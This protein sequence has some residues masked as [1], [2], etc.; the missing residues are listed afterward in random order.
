MEKLGMNEVFKHSVKNSA[1]ETISLSV[2]Y[3][4]HEK[5]CSGQKWGKGIRQQ[6][7]LH[8]VVSGKGTYITPEGSF[9]LST[10]DMFLIRPYTEIEYYA[11]END[12]WEYLWVNFTGTDAETL[13]KR[14][15]FTAA[16]PVIH[17]CDG[18]IKSSMADIIANA[19]TTRHEAAGLTG[20]LYILLSLLMKNSHRKSTHS[21]REQEKRRIIK[22]AKD[23]V[24]TNYPLPVSVEDI[25]DAAG[26]SRTTLFRIFKSELN[27]TP[28]DYLTAYRIAQAKSLLLETDLSVTAVAR[29]AGYEDN[30]YFSR[31]FRKIAGTTPT[32][33]RNCNNNPY[34]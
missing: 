9:E 13:L 11:D 33:Y 1:D 6:Y 27:T 4:G 28:V 19:G 29:S 20:R 30:L 17:G 3:S 8:L 25:A 22:A 14:T 32:E 18:E 12:P 7:I 34:K 16:N 26:V 10:G 23:F 24:A 31:V 2:T 15:D 21:Q 5:C